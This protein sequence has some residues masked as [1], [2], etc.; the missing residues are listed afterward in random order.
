MRQTKEILDA[1]LPKWA[2]KVIALAEEIEDGTGKK[3][4]P[5]EI[6]PF[7]SLYN[8]RNPGRYDRGDIIDVEYRDVTPREYRPITENLITKKDFDD[9][10]YEDDDYDYDDYENGGGTS[11]G[12]IEWLEDV[13]REPSGVH[14]ILGKKG[15][16]KTALSL[17]LAEIM[18]ENFGY[19]VYVMNMISVPEWVDEIIDE[20]RGE[21]RG[22]TIDIFYMING[23]PISP[24]NSIV[25]IDDASTLFDS[26]SQG[27]SAKWLKYLMFITRHKGVILILNSQ[28][29]AALNRYVTTEAAALWVKEP[30]LFIQEG[31]RKSILKVIQEAQKTYETIPVRER[32]QY[33]YA[34][35]PGGRGMVK[36]KVPT[37]WS[38]EISRNKRGVPMRRDTFE[39][40]DE[41]LI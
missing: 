11:S 32:K 3:I 13:L 15:A 20:I 34:V 31:E 19:R 12:R 41:F 6:K 25:I 9:E 16:G 10:D 40:S 39:D 2:R 22:S 7:T 37:G 35:T 26:W 5:K 1:V 21:E 8:P 4:I 24:N 17:R 30:S 36:V 14:L 28:E 18:K 23:R 27:E 38:E 33:V 29:G